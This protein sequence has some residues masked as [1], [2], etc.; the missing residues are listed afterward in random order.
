MLS[1]LIVNWNTKDM[2]RRCLASVLEHPPAGE[3]ETIV[4]DNGSHDGSADMVESEFPGVILVRAGS[5]LGYAA[6]N[7]LAFSKAK[8]DFLLTLNPDT[9]FEDGSLTTALGVLKSYPEYGV[10]GIKLIGLDK[11]VQKS[12]RG[13][14]TIL[15]ILGAWTK[16]DALWP[17][18]PFG[19]YSLPAFDYA[20]DGPAPQP[21]GTFL[22]FRRTSLETVGDPR[23]PF[24]EAFPIF[25]NEVDLLYRLLRSGCPCFYTA[26]A[27]VLHHHGASTKQVRKS[28]IWESHDSLVRYFGKH[29]K[30]PARALLP[31]IAAAAWT[32]AFL[33]A[34][35]HH[36]GFRTQHHDL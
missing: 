33:R 36:A 22:L 28:M 8:G 25:F 18:G 2:L 34:K 26:K 29:L 15:G 4:V 6:G 7:N 16:L 35:G 30:W 20:Q 11:L 12:V 10:L 3:Y 27:H 24:D 31:V 19:S 23:K 17:Y 9:E 1:V 21:M 32:G 14:P 13:F 5:N